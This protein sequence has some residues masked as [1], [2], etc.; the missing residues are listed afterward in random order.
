MDFMETLDCDQS[1]RMLARSGFAALSR[2][3]DLSRYD[4]VVSRFRCPDA[5]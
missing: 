5:N 4:S 1:C 2:R 3:Q